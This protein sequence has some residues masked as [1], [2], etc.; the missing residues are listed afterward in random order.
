[1]ARYS[2][3]ISLLIQT[4]QDSLVNPALSWFIALDVEKITGWENLAE[5]FLR[6]YKFNPKIIHAT[7]DLV[8]V[9]QRRNEPFKAF[10]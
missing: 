6:Q 1:M 8:R 9:E 2:D 3:N 5:E 7:E 4:F 10:A